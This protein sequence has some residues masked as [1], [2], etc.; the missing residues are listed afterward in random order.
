MY[1]AIT[2]IYFAYKAYSNIY[3]VIKA[4]SKISLNQESH[5]VPISLTCVQM[6]LLKEV[7]SDHSLAG[8]IVT[9]GEIILTIFIEVR[10]TMLHVKYKV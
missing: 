4:Y 9:Q 1:K 7:T 2:N 3:F 10:Y 6:Y 5:D 8:S